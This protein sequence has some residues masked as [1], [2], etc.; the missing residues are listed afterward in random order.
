MRRQL[1][2]LIGTEQS[3]RFQTEAR[4]CRA[5]SATKAISYVAPA[6]RGGKIISRQA[7]YQRAAF[8]RRPSLSH[9][10]APRQDAVIRQQQ[11]GPTESLEQPFRDPVYD[12]RMDS[13]QLRP[14]STGLEVMGRVVAEIVAEPIEHWA[15][16]VVG[17]LVGIG[18]VF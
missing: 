16:T 1:Q 10:A 6:P 2:V 14:M 4:Y 11:A 13:W 18:A 5:G 12:L 15:Q 9:T 17:A 8:M 3:G 7:P